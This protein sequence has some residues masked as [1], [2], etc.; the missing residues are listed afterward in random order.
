MFWLLTVL[1]LVSGSFCSN[2]SFDIDTD[3]LVVDRLRLVFP[4]ETSLE[5]EGF[6]SLVIVLP[7]KF[8]WLLP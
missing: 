5:K 7:S 4:V 2:G 8:C 6:G 1:R 3:I